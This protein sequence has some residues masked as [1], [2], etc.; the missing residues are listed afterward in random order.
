MKKNEK[1][2]VFI[3]LFILIIFCLTITY[4]IYGNTLINIYNEKSINNYLAIDKNEPI[5]ILEMKKYGDYVGVLY[6]DPSDK[7]EDND[8]THFVALEKH[9]FYQNRYI[10]KG[11]NYG[12]FTQVSCYRIPDV[13]SENAAYFIFD[14]SRNE[15]K[16]TVFE[17]DMTL[18]ILKKLDEFDVP[19]TP[20]IL[21]KEYK[22]ENEYNGIS[23]YN[24]SITLD[25]LTEE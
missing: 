5:E 3:C 2:V 15:T 18:N 25:E 14:I 21:I 17:E 7:N 19:Q 24:G 1:L 4:L 8:F 23:V 9:K 22:L 20:Y 10:K 11:S 6:I 16:C 12:N 13:D